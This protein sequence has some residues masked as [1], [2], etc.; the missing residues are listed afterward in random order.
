MT[1]PVR[2][3]V[4]GRGLV[5]APHAT[6]LDAVRLESETLAAAVERGERLITDSRGLPLSPDASVTA[7]SIFRT[8]PVRARPTGGQG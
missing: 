4:N 3:F 5:V 2:V 6:A 8:V 7:G 1:R